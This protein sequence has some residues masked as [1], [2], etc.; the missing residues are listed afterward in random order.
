MIVT[1]NIFKMACCESSGSYERSESYESE[2]SGSSEECIICM[3]VTTPETSM[4]LLCCKPID[5]EGHY[6]CNQCISILYAENMKQKHL[7]YAYEAKCPYCNVKFKPEYIESMHRVYLN[8]FTEEQ[9]AEIE[10]LFILQDTSNTWQEQSDFVQ[11]FYE[12]QRRFVDRL[13]RQH[14]K[15]ERKYSK[16]NIARR[17]NLDKELQCI[18]KEERQD[19]LID[20][21][22]TKEEISPEE[23]L[24]FSNIFDHTMKQNHKM[25]SRTKQYDFYDEDGDYD[26]RDDYDHD[27]YLNCYND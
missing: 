21:L 4:E 20:S 25:F 7:N 13:Y 6:I 11:R 5:G 17:Y 8:Y 16:Q 24:R 1:I 12:E 2:S 3:C 19:D 10:S 27:Y 23:S 26:G 22:L 9:R 18:N 14:I 15:N